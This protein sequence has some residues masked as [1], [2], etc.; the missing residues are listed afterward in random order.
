MKSHFDPS[1]DTSGYWREFGFGMV[2]IH[3][4]DYFNIGGLSQKYKEWGEED[5]AFADE[6]SHLGY[7]LF[8]AN[9]DGIEHIWH[10]AVCPEIVDKKKR[11]MCYRTAYS[12]YASIQTLG[13]EYTTRV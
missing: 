6:V 13:K 9:D 12:N 4:S 10:E 5:V 8:R 2:C 1:F 7:E 3:P 11:D